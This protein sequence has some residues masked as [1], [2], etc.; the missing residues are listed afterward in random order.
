[1]TGINMHAFVRGLI[2]KIHTDEQCI[3]YQCIGQKNYK[4]TVKPV[5]D[6]PKSIRAQIQPLDKKSLLHIERVN[7]TKATMQAYLY[8]KEH[9]PITAGS[10]IPLTRSGDIFVRADKTYWLVTSVIEDWSYEGWVKV[11]ITQQVNPSDTEVQA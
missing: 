5:Y 10:R 2:N 9:L 3:L 8:S 4:G 7:D 1:M 11:G 6:L